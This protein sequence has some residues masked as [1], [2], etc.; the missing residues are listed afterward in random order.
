MIGQLGRYILTLLQ[1]EELKDQLTVPVWNL[2]CRY[3]NVTPQQEASQP[4]G[5]HDGTGSCQ[6]CT[7]CH[8]MIHLLPLTILCM[9]LSRKLPGGITSPVALGEMPSKDLR[10]PPRPPYVS[11]S[12]SDWMRIYT[13]QYTPQE[14]LWAHYLP[15]VRE[16]WLFAHLKRHSYFF[17]AVLAVCQS[18]W[19]V[20]EE[21]LEIKCHVSISCQE[22]LEETFY[23]KLYI[24]S[25]G[26][27][28][29]SGM[30]CI[31]PR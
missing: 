6:T 18:R 2:L 1:E 5:M 31:G 3:G 19:H 12:I 22:F 23:S 13:L 14:R 8:F 28:P 27:H 24:C 17:W 15:V 30:F 20:T 4:S 10:P 29:T 9:P 21:I 11:A 7:V 16:L 26:P 25:E